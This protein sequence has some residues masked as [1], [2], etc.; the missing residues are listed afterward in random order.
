MATSFGCKKSETTKPKNPANINLSVL[1]GSW[2]NS[3]WGGVSGNYT[4]FVINDTTAT[5]TVSY[6][7]PE[8]YNFNV[9]DKMFTN[10]VYKSAGTYTAQGKYTFGTD[11]SSTA[12][13]D[14]NIT[15]QNNNTQLTADYPALNA[16]FPEIIY[17][18]QQGSV[19]A[20]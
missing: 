1:E 19:S 20:R 5:G 8:S 12:M 18:F 15:L 16:N 7:G 6:A 14:V 11:N 10:I 4:A 2:Y 17:V 9:G 3:D 13:R